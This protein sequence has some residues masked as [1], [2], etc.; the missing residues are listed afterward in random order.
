MKYGQSESK[1]SLLVN[2]TSNVTAGELLLCVGTPGLTKEF[3]LCIALAIFGTHSNVSK[4]CD[5]IFS[6]I[7]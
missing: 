1:M 2:A 7:S 6:E 4:Y 3:F 5:P